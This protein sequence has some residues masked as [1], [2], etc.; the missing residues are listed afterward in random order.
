MTEPV[1]PHHPIRTCD[2]HA[3]ASAE[4]DRLRLDLMRERE[5]GLEQRHRLLRIALHAAIVAGNLPARQGR[6]S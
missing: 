3:C 2:C 6:S 4:R 5:R 1:D